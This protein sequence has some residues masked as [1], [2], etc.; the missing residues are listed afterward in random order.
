MEVIKEVG[1]DDIKVV[2]I[3]DDQNVVLEALYVKGFSEDKYKKLKKYIK[4]KL[5]EEFPSIV[6]IDTGK[7]LGRALLIGADLVNNS[8]I[9]DVVELESDKVSRWIND[10]VLKELVD[11]V[12]SETKGAKKARKRKSRRKRRKTRRK[13]K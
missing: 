2:F 13:K 10:G 3:R 7:A 5:G 6:S 9:N 4:E 1:G 12:A 11:K 8:L